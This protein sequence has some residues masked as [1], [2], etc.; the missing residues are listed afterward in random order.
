MPA[1]GP[2]TLPTSEL[3]FD[4]LDIPARLVSTLARQEIT[5]PTPVQAAVIP[6]ALAGHDVLGRAQTGS[7]KTL[8]FG[9]PILAKLAGERS[10]PKH[11]RALIIVPTREL[12]TQ[13]RRSM[14]PLAEAMRLKLTTVY[15]GTPYDRQIKQLR[16]GADIVVATPG[17]LED[18]ISRGSCR[19]DDIQITVLDE[20][21]HLCD[22]GFYP[23]VDA[24]MAETPEGSQR[25]LLSAT[26]DGDV[27]KLVRTHLRDPKLHE[28]DPNQGAVTTM[29]HHVMVVGGFRDKVSA[30]T[31][32]VEA[33]PRSIVF[34]RTREG[35]TELADSMTEAGIEAV[36]LHGNL[37]QRVRERNLH[38][39]STGRA[40]VVVATDVAA[41][42]IHVDNV[43]L[44]IHYDAPTDPKAYLHRSGRTAR[45]GESGAVVTITTPRQLD[46]IV[47]LQSSAGVE[48]RHHDI[49]TAPQPMTAEALA[50]SGEAAPVLRRGGSSQSRGRAGQRGGFGGGYRGNREDRGGYRGNREDRGG[51]QGTREDRGGFRGKREDRGGY[52]GNREDRGGYQGKREDRG[53]FRGERGFNREDRGGFRNDRDER[54]SGADRGYRGPRDERDS[55]RSGRPSDGNGRPAHREGRGGDRAAARDDRRPHGQDRASFRD[56]RGETG[57]RADREER[58]GFRSQRPERGDRRE[59]VGSRDR[60]TDSRPDRRT[61]RPD[62]RDRGFRP[63]RADRAERPE[64]PNGG[65]KKPRWSQTGR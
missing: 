37:S 64:A 22:L 16:N 15:G 53:G 20:A 30:T 11:P 6:D 40:Q 8:A 10:R 28:L 18:L 25:L 42:G 59:F 13:V 9:L 26:L 45:A 1:S 55:F 23:V 12:A 54:G 4:A 31:K 63:D 48:S 33:N 32:L 62:F 47:R 24:L 65:K 19:T 27:D 39:F 56:G 38:K 61:D 7:G 34:T 21:D 51:Y 46:Q 44:V 41:R 43:G 57:F 52:Q 14:E 29:A 50:E 49:R 36:D 58:G 5:A 2:A 3:T 60:R 35:A 17:R